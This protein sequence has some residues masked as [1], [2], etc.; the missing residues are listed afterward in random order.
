MAIVKRFLLL[1]SG[2]YFL[3][4]DGSFLIIDEEESPTGEPAY[5]L[6]RDK[7]VFIEHRGPAITPG[8]DTRAVI[9]F[10]DKRAFAPFRDKR[11]V[12]VNN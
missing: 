3:L 9:P 8:E 7:R 2:D 10:R 11:V 4:E 12:N 6:F 5:I 1:E